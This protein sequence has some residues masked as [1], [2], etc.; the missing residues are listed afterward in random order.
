MKTGSAMAGDRLSGVRHNRKMVMELTTLAAAIMDPATK[1]GLL[2]TVAEF[3]KLADFV[4]RAH[5]ISE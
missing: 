1:A 5:E 3:L 4:E 2:E